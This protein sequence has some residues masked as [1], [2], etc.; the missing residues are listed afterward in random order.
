MIFKIVGNQ[1]V[2]RDSLHVERNYATIFIGNKQNFPGPTEIKR[3]TV[4]NNLLRT[5]FKQLLHF[6]CLLEDTRLLLAL[7]I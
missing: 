4:L 2:Q 7:S 1:H 6:L 5:R 3:S